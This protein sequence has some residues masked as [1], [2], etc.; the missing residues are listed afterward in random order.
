MKAFRI[1]TGLA[2]ILCAVGSGA[3]SGERIP[4]IA[5]L[6]P[7]GGQQGTTVEITVGGQFLGGVKDVYVTGT[8]IQASVVKFA[9]PLNN[10][11]MKELRRE[12]NQSMRQQQMDEMEKNLGISMNTNDKAFEPG[13][14]PREDKTEPEVTLPVD[15]PMIQKL[16]AMS[17][18]E[19]K[20][21]TEQYAL[22]NQ[23]QVNSQLADM[24]ILRL[25]LDPDA[26]PGE[27]ELRLGTPSGLT[28]PMCFQVGQMPEVYEK[29]PNDQSTPTESVVN[30][31]VVFNGQ[32]MAGD[33]D[34]F[35]FKARK[36]QQLVA[37]VQAR[38]LVPFLADGVPG[39]FQATI[40]IHDA[41]TN[42]E[43]A[44]ADD[45]RF[46]PDPVLACKI[47]ADGEYEIE[48]HDALYRGREDFVYRIYVG[49]QPFI[50]SMI[51][52]GGQEGTKTTA[53]IRGWNM[54][55]TKQ[56]LDTQPGGDS[57]RYTSFSQDGRAANRLPYAV[58]TLP[59]CTEHESNNTL[60]K[61]QHVSLPLIINGG[62]HTPGDVDFFQFEGKAGE[63]IVGEVSARCLNSPMDSLLRI[64]DSTGNILAWNDDAE[65]INIGLIVQQADSRL[66]ITLPQDGTYYVAI[67]DTQHQGND[68]C[69]YR[70]R[71]AQAQPD[72][73][74]Y[75]TPSGTGIAPGRS[76]VIVAHVVRKDG[77]DGSITLA[78]T[79]APAGFILSGNVIPPGCNRIRMTLTAPLDSFPHL[80]TLQLEARAITQG[81][82]L[83]HPVIPA[84]ELMQA[85]L[86]QHLV[87]A[88]EML[89]RVTGGKRHAPFAA[90]I[91]NAP[92]R[93]PA[94]G[95]VEV[96]VAVP[97]NP[98]L[99][100]AQLALND[101]PK[102][103]AL[104]GLHVVPEGLSFTLKT[105]PELSSKSVQDNLIIDA[106][107]EK[108]AT[109][110]KD[111]PAK[112]G[113]PNQRTSLGVLPALPV[114]II[115][116]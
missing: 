37:Q 60:E 42:Q 25:T 64:M 98:Q 112:R 100:L 44:Y 57:I 3:Q 87:P 76:T 109:Q 46:D 102:G 49:N 56:Q 6:Y 33:I 10:N 103:L 22:T 108:P 113:K 105:T 34:R 95:S 29:E 53:L 111:T 83:Q 47:P 114:E 1:W 27:R 62:I 67:S 101:P 17:P 72:Y 106:F 50:T 9:R 39:W 18:A 21:W 99:P 82:P 61:A 92:I 115:A 93:I 80:A 91:T 65:G 116:P 16:E 104:E 4:H 89:V 69:N 59:E 73:D 11:E 30:M 45:Y 23:K 96:N 107:L 43:L 19:L 81:K 110:E 36:G 84:D 86:Y 26:S 28:N 41:K 12:L 78:L 70:L 20:H 14:P 88:N 71:I 58:N 24:V 74:V 7:A 52:L 79:G 63:Q 66:M 2:V 68:A 8:G 54:P 32:I 5:Y 48:I 55:E 75:I 31:P 97:E 77:F 85:F 51:P 35:R 90:W 94:G 15:H 40:T 13:K 38:R